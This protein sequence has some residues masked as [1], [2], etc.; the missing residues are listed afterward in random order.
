MKAAWYEKQGSPQPLAGE[1]R[2]RVAFSDVNPGDVK[3]R[4]DAFGRTTSSQ[5]IDP[6]GKD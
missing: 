5:S 1:V 4:R 3:K 6:F 2:T